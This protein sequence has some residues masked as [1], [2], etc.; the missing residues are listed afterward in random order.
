[1][2]SAAAKLFQLKAMIM[3][4]VNVDVSTGT[5]PVLE[6]RDVNF[7]WPGGRGLRDVSFSV[8]PGRFVLITGLSGAGKSTLL[9]LIVRLEEI[10]SGQILFEGESLGSFYPPLLRTRIGFVQQTPTVLPGSVRDNLLLPF[11]FQVRKENDIPEDGVLLGWMDRL[12]LDGFGLDSAA[13]DLSVG[14]KQRLCLIRSVLPRPA[15]LCFD[16]PTSALDP[17]SRARVEEVAEELVSEGI[18]VLM[19]SHTGYR[20]GCPHMCIS[21]ADGRVEVQ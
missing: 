7:N 3:N 17:G 15:V 8:F 1:M 19:V 11:R 14:Q 2:G 10:D 20:P 21:V 18:T 9:R 16:E 12:G 6:F 5:L 13:G 4:V